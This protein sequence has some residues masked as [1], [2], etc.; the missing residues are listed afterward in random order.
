MKFGNEFQY[1]RSW[2]LAILKNRVEG[3]HGSPK[4]VESATPQQLKVVASPWLG[5]SS[6]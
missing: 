1:R 3:G 4:W 5:V 2:G 6:S